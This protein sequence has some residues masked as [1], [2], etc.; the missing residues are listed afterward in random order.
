MF[1]Q[2]EQASDAKQLNCGDVAKV[3]DTAQRGKPRGVL[4]I[5]CETE[6]LGVMAKVWV[7]SIDLSRGKNS[8]IM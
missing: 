8:I 6:A 2:H 1:V 5:I 4:Q 7:K 3:I